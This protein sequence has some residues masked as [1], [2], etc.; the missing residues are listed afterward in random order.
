MPFF[1]LV[2]EGDDN[3]EGE[4]LARMKTP[5][6]INKTISKIIVDIVKT[7]GYIG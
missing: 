1:Y 4:D 2:S 3:G 6:K 7:R 5:I